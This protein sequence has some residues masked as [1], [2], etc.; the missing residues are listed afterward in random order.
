MAT[1]CDWLPTLSKLCQ[2]E[3]PN[4]TLDG[5]DLTN[6]IANGA[7][8]PHESFCWQ[9]GNQWAVRKGKWKLLKNSEGVQ[10]YDIPNDLGESRDVSAVHQGTVTE[11]K[12]LY[13]GWRRGNE[14]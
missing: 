9:S 2:A 13:E 7:A 8:S 1:A 4:V 11:L 10:L 3:R 6:V 5:H 12:E 14:S